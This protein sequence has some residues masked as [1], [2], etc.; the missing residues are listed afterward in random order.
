MSSG[1]AARYSEG[2]L[3]CDNLE[4][5]FIDLSIVKEVS[6]GREGTDLTVICKRHGLEE[7]SQSQNWISILYGTNLADN[8]WLHF[9]APTNVAHVWYSGLKCLVTAAQ[10]QKRRSDKRIQWLKEQYLQLYYCDN[11]CQG[12]TPAEAIKVSA[13]WSRYIE[14][15]CSQNTKG[16]DSFVYAA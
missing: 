5:G 15:I 14:N 9:V 4:E 1:L 12:P 11:K 8:H 2:I 16:E 13:H 7:L 10:T 6:L 3:V